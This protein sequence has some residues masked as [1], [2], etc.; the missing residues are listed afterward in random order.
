MT[1][2]QRIQPD[3][4]RMTRRARGAFTLVELLVVVAIIALLIGITL[5]AVQSARESARRTAC[6]NNLR[7]V[8]L[9]LANF[10][11]SKR[12]FPAGNSATKTWLVH[13][14]PYIEQ[15]QV[16]DRSLKEY[17]DYPDQRFLHV[18]MSTP[19]ATYSC[20]SR[21][22]SGEPQWTH[23]RRLVALTDYLGVNGTD[24]L[25]EDGVF[26]R[27]SKTRFRDITDGTSQTVIIGER[28]PSPDY[29]YGWWYAGFGQNGTGSIDMLL[30]TREIRGD[31][32]YTT[33]LESCPTGPYSFMPGD[34]DNMCDAIHFWSHHLGG[35]HFAL[36]DGAVRFMVYESA[37]LLV[38]LGTKAGGEVVRLL[39]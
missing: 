14:L 28:P 33:Y 16:F 3:E 1:A 18:S 7:Q 6:A 37:D 15:Q 11:S 24:Y 12:H 21:P 9:G 29:W 35:A 10:V 38:K 22:G 30:G 17:T 25:S 31:M 19:I 26:Y 34:G 2:N 27:D 20:P 36:A 8:T 32:P 13:V 4:R 23:G 5:P 39:E